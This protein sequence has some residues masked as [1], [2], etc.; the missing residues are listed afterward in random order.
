MTA[1]PEHRR[2]AVLDQT[3]RTPQ[4]AGGGGKGQVVVVRRDVLRVDRQGVASRE[5]PQG[6]WNACVSV[7]SF[8]GA[9]VP[10]ARLER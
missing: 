6:F 8:L 2:V 7:R 5:T 4:V 10:P 3:V 1:S 9:S